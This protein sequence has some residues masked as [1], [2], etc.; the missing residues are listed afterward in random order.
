MVILKKMTL[1]GLMLVFLGTTS[2]LNAMPKVCTKLSKDGRSL[3][4]YPCGM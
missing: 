2:F 1:L 4:L 3:Q